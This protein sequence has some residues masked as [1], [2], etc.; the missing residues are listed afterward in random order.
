MSTKE[1]CK[2][3]AETVKPFL[4]VPDVP[5]SGAW[6]AG[7]T[8][9][10]AMDTDALKI[11]HRNSNRIKRRR[12]PV[13]KPEHY[14]ELP[15]MDWDGTSLLYSDVNDRF[16]NNFEEA[17]SDLDEDQT[18]HDLQLL[19]CKPEYVPELDS[20]HCEDVM[21]DNEELPVEVL[22]AM[23]AFN[24]AIDGIVVSWSPKMVRVRIPEIDE[25][26]TKEAA[27]KVLTSPIN[28]L[29]H[30]DAIRVIKAAKQLEEDLQKRVLN[31]HR[32][33]INT[34][35]FIIYSASSIYIKVASEDNKI[36]LEH[37]AQVSDLLNR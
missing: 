7:E 20:S 32:G 31:M 21:P 22:D 15:V 26:Y 12:L 33:S 37:Y 10:L 13:M 35:S 8:V 28:Q 11:F 3:I 4:T 6:Q 27:Y 1:I 23:D 34:D 36:V 5:F 24:K 14:E 19:L 17:E 29:S 18:L 30:E 25:S 16:Y 9:Y 2:G